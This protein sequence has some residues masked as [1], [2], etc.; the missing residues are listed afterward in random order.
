MATCAITAFSIFSNVGSFIFNKG[1]IV[2]P[3]KNVMDYYK[4]LAEDSAKKIYRK[5]GSFKEDEISS[6]K[7]TNSN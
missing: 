3:F 4:S 1:K 2:I 7:G 5:S 6:I